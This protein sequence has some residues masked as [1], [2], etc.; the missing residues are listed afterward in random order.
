MNL[1]GILGVPRLRPTLARR[2]FREDLKARLTNSTP[3]N[4]AL[5]PI[6]NALEK[7]LSSNHTHVVRNMLNKIEKRRNELLCE[8]TTIREIDFGAGYADARY[9]Q[10]YPNFGIVTNR[11]ISEIAAYSKDK[12]WCQFLFDVTVDLRPGRVLEMG[13][14][15]GISGSYIASALAVNG[16][17]KVWTIEGSPNTAL[18]AR[19]TFGSL[20]L[21]E[22]VTC[23]AGPF[24]EV[25]EPCLTENGPF[26]LVFVDGHHDGTATVG[27]YQRIKGNLR[28]GAVVIF[29]DI[30]WSADMA[31]AWEV[32]SHD[33]AVIGRLDLQ[34]L[35]L[36]L[37]SSR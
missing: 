29:D 17:G 21:S 16:K 3:R 35:G 8:L 13:T 9:T 6:I 4:D 12:N 37:M 24:H 22:I 20:G 10:C 25:L 19:E 15:V 23:I 1:R 27:Y 7:S 34:D 18:L 28:P 36:V 5:D 31:D 32:I 33:Q 11:P 26:D 2:R 30:A 14:C